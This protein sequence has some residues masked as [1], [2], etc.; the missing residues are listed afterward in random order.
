MADNKDYSSYILP[1]GLVLLLG[2][3]ASKF[4]LIPSA[5][6]T[7]EAENVDAL[8]L[9]DYFKGDYPRKYALSKGW[10]KWS[11]AELQKPLAQTMVGQLYNAK[12]IFNDDEL[13]V[14]SVFKRM[15]YKTQ[16]TQ[17]ANLFYLE[18]KKD[19]L[20]YLKSFMSDAELS[21]IYTIV[22]DLPAG[23]EQR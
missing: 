16:I 17:V 4:G 5:K 12:R 20:E 3:I 9:A 11:R 10:Q 6:S 13:S 8:D 18:H 1:V 22:K 7:Q 15:R 19:L 21:K 23:V 2:S 14:Y